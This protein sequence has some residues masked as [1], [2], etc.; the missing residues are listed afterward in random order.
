MGYHN[1]FIFA[2]FFMDYRLHFAYHNVVKNGD[3]SVREITPT[4]QLIQGMSKNKAQYFKSFMA[5]IFK[6]AFI[7]DFIIN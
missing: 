3:V 5:S 1:W 7:L 4:Q 6:N 2:R